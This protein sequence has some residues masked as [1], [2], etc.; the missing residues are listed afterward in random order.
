VGSRRRC[1]A[2]GRP[3][4]WNW[5]IGEACENSA[6]LAPPPPAAFFAMHQRVDLGERTSRRE[7][8]GPS[9]WTALSRNSRAAGR[10]STSG[11]RVHL[12]MAAPGTELPIRDVRASVAI[13]GKPTF[14]RTR[15]SVRASPKPRGQRGS[16][17]WRRLRPPSHCGRKRG[18]RPCSSLR[19]DRS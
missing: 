18:R 8:H 13:E 4:V 3:G 5:H 17:P 15:R 6:D 19:A 2:S 14:N 9:P 16:C 12:L 7:D 11:C 10:R 1:A